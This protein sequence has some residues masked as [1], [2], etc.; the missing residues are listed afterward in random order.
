MN[1]SVVIKYNDP[2]VVL[3]IRSAKLLKNLSLIT[4]DYTEKKTEQTIRQS[5]Y[6]VLKV[7]EAVTRVPAVL[8]QRPFGK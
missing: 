7:S 3:S 4:S 2:G 6:N 5:R 8:R 1:A